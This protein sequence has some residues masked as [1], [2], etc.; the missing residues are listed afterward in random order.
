MTSYIA[1][2]LVEH[3]I[4]PQPKDYSSFSEVIILGNYH[5]PENIEFSRLFF[6]ERT[7]ISNKILSEIA[8]KIDDAYENANKE[9]LQSVS[10]EIV[11]IEDTELTSHLFGQTDIHILDER[12]YTFGE[13]LTFE[14]F[15][16]RYDIG[17]FA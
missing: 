14:E 9:I 12:L 8:A 3:I 13:C 1:R 15:K 5:L 16:K 2:V 11:K 10:R 6:D 7:D 17:K 4:S